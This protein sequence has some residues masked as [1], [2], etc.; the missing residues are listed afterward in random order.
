MGSNNGCHEYMNFRL[1]DCLR[2]DFI[3][4]QGKLMQQGSADMTSIA[5]SRVTDSK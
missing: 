3:A 2:V 5:A 4:F 1:N